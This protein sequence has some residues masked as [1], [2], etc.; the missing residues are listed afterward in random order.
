MLKHL[1]E[2]VITNNADIGFAFDGD[3]DRCGYVDN[4]GN[5]IFSDIMGLLLARVFLKIQIFKICY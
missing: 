3:G 1:S 4:N 2:E 5:E